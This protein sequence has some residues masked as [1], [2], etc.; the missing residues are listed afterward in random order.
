M[1]SLIKTTDRVDLSRVQTVR[2]GLGSL[3]L[4]PFF[5]AAAWLA[6][7][8]GLGVHF[9]SMRKGL[10]LVIKKPCKLYAKWI[11]YPLDSTRYVEIDFVQRHA[12]QFKTWLD[13]SSPRLIAALL[14]SRNPQ[15]ASTLLNPDTADMA[16]T[17]EMAELLGLK[18]KM[19]NATLDAVDASERF[20]LVTCVSVLEHIPNDF[21]VLNKLWQ[22]LNAGGRLILT[23]PA[24][25]DGGTQLID[26]D[27]YGTQTKVDG[28]YFFQRF[29]SGEALQKLEQITGRPSVVEIWGE[30]KKGW[31]QANFEHKR[32][33]P[34]YPVWREP[35][36]MAKNWRRFESVSELPGEGVVCAV[37]EKK[38]G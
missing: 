3:L 9:F 4:S 34:L 10:K 2:M 12:G 38:A 31:L 35:Y 22:M 37:Y 13:L 21:E 17:K 36:G 6:G 16:E 7:G 23:I 27:P 30:R 15:A 20:D 26:R 25:A 5:F 29:Y 28:G 8:R 19:I 32:Q 14:L 24:Y 1:N 33:D 11:Y 18:C